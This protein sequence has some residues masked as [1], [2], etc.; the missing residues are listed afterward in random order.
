AAIKALS[1]APEDMETR[2]NDFVAILLDKE[3]I[4]PADAQGEVDLDPTIAQNDNF[5]LEVK[6]YNDAQELLLADPIHEV[7]ED[8][9][10]T[11]EKSSLETD[12]EVVKAKESKMD[13]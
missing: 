6:E 1:A 13:N 4:L 2:L 5:V 9:G 11:P 12:K 3:L 8:T 10:W 7:K